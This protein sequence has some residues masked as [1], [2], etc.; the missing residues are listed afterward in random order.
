[1]F[2][3]MKIN[4]QMRLIVSSA[5]ILAIGLGLLS[6]VTLSN[7][8]S[9]LNAIIER[10]LHGEKLLSETNNAIWELRFGIANYTLAKPDVRAKIIEGR[11]PFYAIVEK[12]AKAYEALH[13][14]LEQKEKLKEFTDFYAQY[15]IGAIKWFE[16][17]DNNKMEEAADFRAKVT[18]F[19]GSEMVK[20]LKILLEMQVKSNLELK[21]SSTNDANNAKLQIILVSI[22]FT[23]LV[24]VL[25]LMIARAILSSM[26]SLQKGLLSFFFFLHKEIDK[27]DPITLYGDNEFGQMAKTIN[28]NIKKIETELIQDNNMV[29]NTL[30]IVSK[31]KE[32]HLNIKI[33]QTPN[34]PQL[35]ELKNVFN[36]MLASLNANI[37]KTLNVLNTYAKNDFTTRANK[38]LL[39]GEV[40]N[41]IDGVNN[42]GY[43]ISIML[44]ASRDNGDNLFS[45][46]NAL[47]SKMAELT[48]FTTQQAGALKLT[49]TSIEQINEA[50]ENSSQKTKD[51]VSQSSDIK[52]I[53]EIIKDIADQTNLLALNAAIEAA[54]AGEHGRGF[55]V[56]SDEV[57]K[58]AERTQKSLS[59]I[60]ATIG[61]LSQSITDISEMMHEQVET[62]S[63]INITIS[64]IDE[65]TQVNADSANHASTIAHEVEAMSES[66]LK[67]VNSKK[68]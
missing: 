63:H 57:R 26:S 50:I 44:K 24:I 16:L 46:A 1:M 22:I 60:N 31:V 59:E 12:N 47:K 14:S 8:L 39:S 20:R 55:A 19:A 62:I 43:E 29:T 53:I 4:T 17:I 11:T 38:E 61:L 32:G 6:Y 52:S 66:M 27:A 49:A 54:R 51:I 40:A 64:Q 65:T 3:N 35:L 9:S 33:E 10:G 36:E 58:L 37:G 2:K 25:T 68:F 23:I 18:N 67:D 34:N 56:V 21:E 48:S 7:T 13:L 15:K 41:L 5:L 30:D 42:L 28:E 45:K